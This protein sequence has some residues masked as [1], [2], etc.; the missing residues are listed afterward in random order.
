MIPRSI[1]AVVLLLVAGAPL[2]GAASAQDAVTQPAPAGGRADQLLVGLVIDADGEPVA[3]VPVALHRVTGGGGALVDNVTTDDHGRFRIAVPD[4]DPD[5][6]LFV[7]ARYRGELYIGPALRAPFP[8]DADYVLQ[9]GVEETSAAAI[10]RATEPA[11][12]AMRPPASPLRWGIAVAVFAALAAVSFLLIRRARG[13][14]ARRRL[15]IRIAE[16]DNAY[17]RDVANGSGADAGAEPDG[18]NHA[19][20]GSQEEYFERRQELVGRLRALE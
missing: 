5:A 18:R 8:E 14:D 17:E 15:L 12:V 9:V 11:P 2:V 3:A 7:A 1:A 20:A 16:L 6:V 4:A 10:M 19:A 13:P